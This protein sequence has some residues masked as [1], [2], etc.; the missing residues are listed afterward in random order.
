MNQYALVSMLRSLDIV[1][2]EKLLTI[3]EFRQAIISM[4]SE[5]QLVYK[6]A[7]Q[8][9]VRT[10]MSLEGYTLNWKLAWELFQLDLLCFHY[11]AEDHEYLR[12]GV[13][14][15]LHKPEEIQ[16]EFL[17]VMVDQ[18]FVK[19][20]L[21]AFKIMGPLFFDNKT[22]K[23]LPLRNIWTLALKREETIVHEDFLAWILDNFDEEDTYNITERAYRQLCANGSL[24]TVKMLV[25]RLGKKISC[26]RGLE[27]AIKGGHLEVVRLLM[28][29]T[30]IPVSLNGYLFLQTAI[31]E[32]QLEIF[33]FLMEFVYP[34]DDLRVLVPEVCGKGCGEVFELLRKRGTLKK[35]T[36]WGYL[37]EKAA[38]HN[39]TETLPLMLEHCEIPSKSFHAAVIGSYRHGSREAA[40]FLVK[41]PRFDLNQISVELRYGIYLLG[42][43]A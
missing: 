13:A 4:Q 42:K 31:L 18:V 3:D 39:N 12:L 22:Q 26:S 5:V 7:L 33:H 6:R 30:G 17:S 40:K 23:G 20:D 9:S 28:T 36:D 24:A 38:L 35:V 29:R 10:G 32:N 1:T 8:A 34:S 16:A 41:Q 2:L 37:F 43:E 14:L 15:K 27:D 25:D 19:H 21:E 11:D